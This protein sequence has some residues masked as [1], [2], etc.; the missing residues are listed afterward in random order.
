MTTEIWL[1]ALSAAALTG[2]VLLLGL[3]ARRQRPQ[4]VRVHTRPVRRFPER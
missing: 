1:A 2:P 3:R 4:P